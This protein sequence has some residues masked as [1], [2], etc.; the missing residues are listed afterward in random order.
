MSKTY[1]K[2]DGDG[3]NDCS[4]VLDTIKDCKENKWWADCPLPGDPENQC[5]CSAIADNFTKAADVFESIKLAD[6][7]ILKTQ[8]D[9]RNKCV[10][11]WGYKF[12]NPNDKTDCKGK[13][14]PPPKDTV[15]TFKNSKKI[16]NG[17]C[18]ISPLS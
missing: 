4:D 18:P 3:V 6:G 17:K 13:D 14:N 1:V 10:N 15:F 7:T 5:N 2:S 16:K 9:I 12:T 8:K 11:E